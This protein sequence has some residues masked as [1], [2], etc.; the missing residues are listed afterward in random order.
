MNTSSKENSPLLV[1]LTGGIGSGKSVIAK[2]FMVL[3]VP[4]FN[5]DDI[6]KTIVDTDDE[7]K[8][9]IVAEF[10]DVYTNSRLESFNRKIS[11]I[12]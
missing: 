4:V 3:G 11:F 8:S 9:K 2:I 6:A 5:S 1:G 12:E 7:V 10:G